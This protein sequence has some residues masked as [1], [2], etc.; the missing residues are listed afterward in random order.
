MMGA[1]HYVRSGAT[2]NGSGSDWTNAC[3][4][5]TGSCAS[6]VRGD[7]Y[8][9]AEGKYA[10]RT[11]STPA[12]GTTRIIIKKAT[13]TDYGSG[14]GWSSTYGD[15]PAVFT[16][17]ST[18]DIINFSTGYWT[19]DGVTGGGPDS[20]TTGLGFVVDTSISTDTGISIG[21]NVNNITVRHVEVIGDGGDGD[22][23]GASNHGIY[24]GA[25]SGGHLIEYVYVHHQGEVPFYWRSHNTTVQY[26]WVAYNEST[27]GA[28]SEGA[29]I[30]ADQSL[31]NPVRGTVIRYNVWKEIEG[32]GT[33]ACECDGADIYG[34]VFWGVGGGSGHGA[35]TSWT[36]S[37]A[38]NIR[39]YNNTFIDANKGVN[40]FVDGTNPIR[41]NI[42]AYNNLFYNTNAA[43]EKVTAHDYNWF[44]NAGGTFSEAHA[45]TGS[46]DPFVNKA[47][48]DFHLTSRTNSGMTIGAPFNVDADGV[49]RVSDGIWDR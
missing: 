8:Y 16:S 14:A 33:I 43:F 21:A 1:N 31:T 34:N 19:F 35:V 26:S 23:T 4:D 36:N 47:A 32:T 39:V 17:S 12:N 2:G 48:A 37:P 27:P 25:G 20:W 45:Q 15:G 38:L 44:Y 13:A 5:F 24:T 9:V 30:S 28:H 42:V 46:G 10:R 18:G 3:T 41:S 40:F 22:G 7:T 11:F 6:L 49:V 29:L